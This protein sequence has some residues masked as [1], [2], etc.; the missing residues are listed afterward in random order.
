[1]K[2]TGRSVAIAGLAGGCLAAA[3]AGAQPIVDFV[4]ASPAYEYAAR[5]YREIWREYGAK[6]VAALEARTCL[7]FAEARVTAVVSDEGSD[8]GG[9]EHSMSLRAGYPVSVKQ[10]TL[11]HELGHRHL[12]QLAERLDGVDGHRTLYLILD[13]VWADVWGEAFAG[14][15]VQGES[16][17]SANYDYAAA[18]RWARA[19]SPAE[20]AALWNRLLAA[21]GI[22]SRCAG[23]LE[24]PAVD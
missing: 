23:L 10:S 20:R 14:Y 19:L 11:V 2:G 9:P 24:R 1:M 22:T 12:W 16:A 18:W 7:R 8:S 21:N 15:R 17:W 13:A 4:P 5:E 3:A 6:I